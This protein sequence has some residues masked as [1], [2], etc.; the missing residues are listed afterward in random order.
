M[1]HW[2]SDYDGSVEVPF[3]VLGLP[4]IVDELLQQGFTESEIRKVMGE[5]V[6]DLLLKMLP[7]N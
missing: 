3:N 1:L 5:N 7:E 6:R 4:I 2:G